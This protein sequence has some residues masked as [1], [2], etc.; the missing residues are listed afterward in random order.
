MR[1]NMGDKYGQQDPADRWHMLS[2]VAFTLGAC[3]AGGG[4]LVTGFVV[5]AVAGYFVF[6]ASR[7]TESRAPYDP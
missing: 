4:D 7:A 1:K 3:F 2:F 6:R 5:W